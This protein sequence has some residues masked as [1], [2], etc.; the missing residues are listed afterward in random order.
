MTNDAARDEPSRDPSADSHTSRSS[1]RIERRQLRRFLSPI[2]ITGSSVVFLLVALSALVVLPEMLL[3]DWLAFLP[4]Q[5]RD[6]L[7]RLSL[8]QAAQIVLFGL[9]GIIAIVG[10]GLSLSR[11]RTELDTADDARDKEDR[12]IAELEIQLRRETERDL[13]TRFT[14]AVSLLSDLEKATTRQAGAYALAAL[15]DDWQAFGRPDERQIC[16]DVL[17]GYLRSEWDPR[18]QG[19]A[20]ERRIRTT[21]FDLISSHFR[22]DSES[23]LWQGADIN[24]EGA[25]IAFD[26]DF[27]GAN[28]SAGR[29]RFDGVEISGGRVDFRHATFSGAIVRFDGV[30]LSGGTADFRDATFSG[31]VVDF[32]DIHFFDKSIL[33]E[34][35]KFS[36]ATVTFLG[37]DIPGDSM[38]DFSKSEFT[39]GRVTFGGTNS[40]H[41][42]LMFEEA[43]FSGGVVVFEMKML[44]LYNIVFMRAQILGGHIL[45]QRMLF[46]GCVLFT[47]AEM[48]D[49]L[50]DFEHT[51][52]TSGDLVFGGMRFLGGVIRL[53]P[54]SLPEGTD[55]SFDG[56]EFSGTLDRD[57]NK[58]VGLD[59]PG[60]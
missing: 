46:Q 6:A 57:G 31:G 26:V 29:V 33:F 45:F 2:W 1:L 60:T 39:A 22:R 56:A 30:K 36:G 19:G 42:I 8:G 37:A 13:R 54:P 25:Q 4:N 49:G 7:I 55:I 23:A 9:G 20:E 34:R 53:E 48:R 32:S 14:T 12:R 16:I 17:C 28:F 15:A 58:F 43:T 5:G 35:S 3:K 50:I 10:V 52:F 21:G 59:E 18:G 51:F 24:L 41:G 38:V 40:S 27:S 44:F 11:H 47:N